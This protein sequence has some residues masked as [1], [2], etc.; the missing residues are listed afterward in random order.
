M[1]N[2]L[3]RSATERL[4]SLDVF[5]G[6][7]IAG[8]VLVN[9]PG[10]WNHIYWPLAHASWHGWTPT[11]LIFPFFLFIVGV[12]IALALGSRVEAKTSNRD[13]YFKIIKRAVIIFALGLF[14][15]GFP[16]FH[17]GTIRIMGV[18]QRIAICYLV[19]ALIFINTDLRKQL[20]IAVAL[21]VGYWIILTVIPTPGFKLA[22]YSREGSIACFVDRKV[23]GNHIWSQGKIYDPEGLLSTLPAI[24]TTLLGVVTGQ[25]LRS[26][27]KQYEKISLLFV[28]GAACVIAGWLWNLFFPINK[29]L[30]TSS[31]VMFTG[32]LAMQLLALCYW[33]IDIKGYRRWSKPLVVF[34]VNAIALFVGT[35]LMAKLMGLI[36]IPRPDG[37]RIAL[38][39]WIYNGL[40]SSWAAPYQASLLFAIAFVLLWLGLMWLLY[41]WKIFI[42]I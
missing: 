10:S 8:M 32:G 25:L 20:I 37:S 6:L 17:L 41:R 7:T 21:V 30:W 13:L 24:A 27:R 16:Y 42:K 38:K 9:N 15:A 35:G 5:R 2:T 29:S 26:A 39:T 18:L 19:A 34:G 22:D 4:I 23:L 3:A 12:S 28:A 36:K 40:F 31:Y 33:L 1:E 14:L 11:D